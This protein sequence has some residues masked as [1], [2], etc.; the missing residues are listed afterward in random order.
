MCIRNKE[1]RTLMCIRNKDSYTSREGRILHMLYSSSSHTLILLYIRRRAHR[2]HLILL[3]YTR[4]GGLYTQSARDVYTCAVSL[5]T[6]R[7][8]NRAVCRVGV[9]GREQG[10]GGDLNAAYGQ[11]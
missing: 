7:I 9:R 8:V 1:T 6:R 10:E 11:P 3:G 2:I 4:G 5:Y